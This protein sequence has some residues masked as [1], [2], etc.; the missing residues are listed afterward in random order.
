MSYSRWQVISKW[1]VCVAFLLAFSGCTQMKT[2]FK[3]KSQSTE[4]QPGAT[5]KAK[6]TST[7]QLSFAH[8]VRWEG[9]TLSLIAEWYTGSQKNWKALAKANSWLDPD[10]I[11]PGHKVFIPR[12][13]LKTRKPMPRNFALS[14]TNRKAKSQAVRATRQSEKAEE[15][16][17]ESKAVELEFV[18]P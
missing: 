8:K 4:A 5:G 16:L 6:R 3:S 9:E 18:I 12:S 17:P 2:F 15:E 13:L 1:L 7:K 11:L 14:S 10:N